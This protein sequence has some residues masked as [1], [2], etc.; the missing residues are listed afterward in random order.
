MLAFK[1]AIGEIPPLRE[2]K[3][4][5]DRIQDGPEVRSLAA[6]SRELGVSAGRLR[7]I[8]VALC[9]RCGERP[10]HL[11]DARGNQYRWQDYVPVAETVVKAMKNRDNWTRVAA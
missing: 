5:R 1:D 2:P 4:L 7:A 11:G 10:E 6:I 8:A 3:D 9:V